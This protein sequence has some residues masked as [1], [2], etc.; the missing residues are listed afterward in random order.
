MWFWLE[1]G[2]YCHT[3]SLEIKQLK[4]E[5]LKPLNLGILYLLNISVMITLRDFGSAY[6]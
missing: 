2:S 4:N 1:L 5:E 3:E 6:M